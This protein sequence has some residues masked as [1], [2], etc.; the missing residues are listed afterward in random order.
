MVNE[1][2]ASLDSEDC[3]ES[4]AKS[5]RAELEK[6]TVKY[7]RYHSYLM[8]EIL[9]KQRAIQQKTSLPAILEARM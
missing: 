8:V 4:L 7:V 3:Q 2:D 9:H 5:G 1:D 6:S